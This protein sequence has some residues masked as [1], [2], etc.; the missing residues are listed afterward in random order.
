MFKFE[1]YNKLGTLA[2][3]R[4][5]MQE[6]F[7]EMSVRHREL[8]KMNEDQALRLNFDEQYQ[9]IQLL[10]FIAGLE[11]IITTHENMPVVE[12]PKPYA[13]RKWQGARSYG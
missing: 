2:R 10:R 5:V 9:R 4:R 11:M 13:K 7:V 3:A 6:T 1:E 12:E 8:I